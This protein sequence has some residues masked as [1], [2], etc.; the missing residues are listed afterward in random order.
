MT[1]RRRSGHATTDAADWQREAHFQTDGSIRTG[2]GIRPEGWWRFESGRPDLA[3]DATMD[4]YAHLRPE[5]L[6]RPTER[7]AYLMEHGQ[8]SD[9]ELRA[10]ASGLGPSYEWRRAVLAAGRTVR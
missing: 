8:L 7:L 4:V 1:R 3:A 2:L 10:I 6:E 9:G 5:R